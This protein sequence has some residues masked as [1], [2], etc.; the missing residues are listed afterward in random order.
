MTTQAAAANAT[1]MDAETLS[2]L[3]KDQS[4]KIK[5]LRAAKAGDDEL[6]REIQ[7]LKDLQQQLKALS[8]DGG[9]A[10]AGKKFTVKT[11]KVLRILF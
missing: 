9:D 7:V 10:G 5:A 6:T 1:L 11:P 4:A 2:K 8:V 3:T